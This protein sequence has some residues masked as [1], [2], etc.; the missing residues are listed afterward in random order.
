M[1]Y[2]MGFE[3]QASQ[4]LRRSDINARNVAGQLFQENATRTQQLNATMPTNRDL[5]NKV[6]NYGFQKI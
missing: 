6:Y 4:T 1:L 5:I 3:T 2:G